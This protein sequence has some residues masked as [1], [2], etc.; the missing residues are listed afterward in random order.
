MLFIYDHLRGW[1]KGADTTSL[2]IYLEDRFAQEVANMS[3]DV[4]GYFRKIYNMIVAANAFMKTLFHCAL[5][6]TDLERNAL[7][8]SGRIA[9]GL[10]KECANFAYHEGL[11]RWKLQPKYHLYG[12]VIFELELDKANERD[13][14]SP[15]AWST[16]MDEDFVGHIATASRHVSIRTLHEKTLGRFRISLAQHWGMTSQAQQSS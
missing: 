4:V 5:W 13:S 6:L 15:L 3:G 14:I 8:K 1:Y 2:L 7:I 12:E 9:T 16:Q 11:C 10:F